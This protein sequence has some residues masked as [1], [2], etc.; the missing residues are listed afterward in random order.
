MNNDKEIIDKKKYDREYH[1]EYNKEYYKKNKDIIKEY[2]EKNKDKT[3]V[4]MK[5]Y[6]EK[7]KEKNKDKIKVY[8]KEYNKTYRNNNKNSII[9]KEKEY[10]ENNNKKIKE[11][12]KEYYE[13]NKEAIKENTKE[14]Y[15]NN[16]DKVKEKSK[17]RSCNLFSTNKS[18]N[19][20]CSYCNPD[21]SKHQKTKEMRVKTFLEENNYKFI[22][23]KKCNL[24]NSCQTYYP[25]FI[26]DCN[27]FFLIIECDENA[28]SSYDA[29]CEKIRENNICY[30]LGLPCVF[31]R[32]NPDLKGVKLKIK[33]IVL[34]SYI[35]YYK[36]LQE[37]DNEVQ[38][39]FY[40]KV[41]PKVKSKLKKV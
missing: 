17:C 18:T 5:E 28:H 13:N 29:D 34:K 9:E 37:C 7:N 6:K 10:R 24:D 39:L 25:D 35:E 20:L 40:T 38:Y 32:Y 21:K 3:K 41:E 19:Y 1:R 26:I 4:Y 36:N 30:A 15:E 12:K 16:K 22:H 2:K 23:N 14:Y 27:R 33:E 31:I 8:M 11:Y